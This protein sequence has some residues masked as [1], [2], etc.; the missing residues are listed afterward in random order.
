MSVVGSG[1]LDNP[2]NLAVLD[3][4]SAATYQRLV[5]LSSCTTAIGVPSLAVQFRPLESRSRYSQPPIFPKSR[6]IE[7]RYSLDPEP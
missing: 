7:E 1:K 4:S 6:S 5:D 2:K 3:K